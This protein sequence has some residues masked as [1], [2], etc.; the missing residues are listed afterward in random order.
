MGGLGYILRIGAAITN[1]M[2]IKLAAPDLTAILNDPDSLHR[3][4]AERKLRHFIPLAWPIV[5]PNT[6]FKPNWHID[7]ICDHL[8]AVF[9][10]EIKNLLVNVPPR[11]MK[12]LT[13]SVFWPVWS[14][15]RN[16]GT[17][18]LFSSYAHTLAIRDAV[19]S[20]RI[21]Q[22][23]WFKNLWGGAFKLSGD[24]N[25]KQR[26][27]NTLGGYR[28]ATSVGGAVTGEG[29]DYVVVDDPHNIVEVDSDVIREGVIQ[30]WDEVMSTRL[31]SPDT[32]GRIIIMQRSHQY[33]LAGHVL[34]KG[35]YEHL[36]LPMEFETARACST[37]IGFVDPRKEE[38]ELLCPNRVGPETIKSLK[39]ALGSYGWAG[40]MQQRPSARE[41]NMFHV[42]ELNVVQTIKEKNVKK[43]WRSWDKAATDGGGKFTVGIRMG[44]YKVPRKNGS[45]DKDG[46]ERKSKYFIDDIVRG[47]WST[48]VRE[49][50]IKLASKKDTKT[51]WIIIEQEPGSGGKSDA[52][53]TQKRLVGRHVEL[54]RPTG[55]KVARADP[56]SVAVENGEVDVLEAPWTFELIEEL[57][58]FPQSKYKDQVD[59]GSMAFNKLSV[60]G[61]VHFG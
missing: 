20:R 35:D 37:S 48:G 25:A 9:D 22:S 58:H 15:I 23:E 33:D 3:E 36:M 1:L 53:A 60:G 30:W 6:E 28:I 16:P 8:Q 11:A 51:V 17:R 39:L 55:D 44:K 2:R 29:G 42:D 41:G 52:E 47:Q 59:A 61:K 34:E 38:G 24:Q 10:G 13:I 18:W 12:S 5:E 19:K 43:R 50:K 32:G 46:K 54:E 56:F 40:Q 21:I 4:L 27:E 57:K 45:F 7:A 14:W 26:Y 31:N 49:D